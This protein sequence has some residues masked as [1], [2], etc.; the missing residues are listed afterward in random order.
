MRTALGWCWV[1]TFDYSFHYGK[2]ISLLFTGLS[3]QCNSLKLDTFFSKYVGLTCELWS[4]GLWFWKWAEKAIP[5]V[6]RECLNKE[7]MQTLTSV[8]TAPEFSFPLGA[9]CCGVSLL[10]L[11]SGD[12]VSSLWSKDLLREPTARWGIVI[13]RHSYQNTLHVRIRMAHG[14]KVK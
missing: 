14:L 2:M 10:F 12:N 4:C 3:G 5:T 13:V 8:F 9:P 7:P 6:L 11:C 1:N